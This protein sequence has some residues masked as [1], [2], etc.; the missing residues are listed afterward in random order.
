MVEPPSR[1]LQQILL[2]LKLCS[3]RD[4]RRCASRVKA[5]A[6]DL[7]AFDSVWLDALVQRRVLTSWQAQIIEADRPELLRIGPGIVEDRIGQSYDSATYRV[8]LPGEAGRC[9]V[10]RIAV[11]TELRRSVSDRLKKLVE[12]SPGLARTGIVVPHSFSEV[13]NEPL[14]ELDN[15]SKLR[16]S[17]STRA[18]RQAGHEATARKRTS[19][20]GV[21]QPRR[22][23]NSSSRPATRQEL[24]SDLAIVSR[25]I[26]GL[27]LSEILLRR[28][29][30]PSA[31]VDAIARQLLESLATLHDQ[32]I[33]HGDILLSNIR[34]TPTGN[35]VLVD[36]GIRPA[37]QPEFQISA[38]VPPARNDG[39]APELIGTGAPVTPR[40]DLYALGF[41]LWNLL[42]GRPAFPT[43]DPL[44]KLA[45]HQTERIPDI[46]EFA[47]DTPERLAR[48]IEW[49]TEPAASRR[50][51]SARQLLHDGSRDHRKTS[52]TSDSSS[53]RQPESSPQK[54]ASGQ[55]LEKSPKLMP[56]TLTVTVRPAGRA[57]RRRLSKF[58]ASFQQPLQRSVQ[59]SST[60]RTVVSMAFA[61]AAILIAIATLLT[62]DARSRN[63]ILASLPQRLTRMAAD[64]N[65]PTNGQITTVH[66]N[67][68][69]ATPDL[70][71]FD[72]DAG[73]SL[74]MK[75]ADNGQINPR[76]INGPPQQPS[77]RSR[78]PGTTNDQV[79]GSPSVS[80]LL[81]LPEPD[82]YGVI[83]LSEPGLY[84]AGSISWP[85]S[86]LI[87]RAP[88]DQ[89]ATII[90]VSRP[91]QLRATE[92]TLENV[93]I[94][95][96]TGTPPPVVLSH[97]RSQKL[98]CFNCEFS[99]PVR[100]SV[101]ND[102]SGSQA[103]RAVLANGKAILW[104]PI[105]PSDPLAGE[106][107][108]E[109]CRLFGT[110]S[111]IVMAAPA[112][113]A[114]CINTLK[115]GGGPLFIATDRAS[116][117]DNTLELEHSTLRNCGSLMALDLRNTAPWKSRLTVRQRA[118]VFDLRRRSPQ[119]SESLITFVGGQLQRIWHERVSFDGDASVASDGVGLAAWQ[120]INGV[121]HQALDAADVAVRGL[122]QTAFTFQNPPS[123]N[124]SDSVLSDIHTNRVSS[125]LPGIS[126][127]TGDIRRD[128]NQEMLLPV[129]ELEPDS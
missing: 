117:G 62:F 73:S 81:P 35:V 29:R 114:R 129:P 60:R 91:L 27:S 40:S 28:G 125:A 102:V 87:V 103:N 21:G 38:H 7:P 124:R 37:L 3:P 4:L 36:A 111:S 72:K 88:I 43:G 61:S 69:P 5:L 54:K 78:N 15:Q 86:R 47:P 25:L 57:S 121:N 90:V 63:F 71:S 10:K 92:V 52:R 85:G 112:R 2:G 11:P 127:S 55:S 26:E 106:L 24:Q 56:E 19:R 113:P 12:Q 42:A 101:Q 16:E 115:L 17:A 110:H 82:P 97:I 98:T 64:S 53:T 45:A 50:P 8:R 107:T 66:G 9:V 59:S 122:I 48:M 104:G 46:R 65:L 6:A 68:D 67:D 75:P 126:E 39:I 94:Q 13:S 74:S 41:A 44:A 89:P 93:N 105:D 119:E 109:D 79:P 120:A 34:L 32:E 23:R 18:S 1:R 83:E 95:F 99:S 20:A 58:A 118:S 96:Q 116:S 22:R 128:V 76:V 14:P 33:V 100:N 30:L 51:R 49:L 123:R 84:V 80:E 70:T 31:D 77:L 108:F